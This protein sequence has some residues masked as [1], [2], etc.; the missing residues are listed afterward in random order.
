VVRPGDAAVTSM[1]AGSVPRPFWLDRPDVV[2]PDPSEPLRG[3]HDADL[4]IIGAGFT[5]LWAAHQ[6]L[7]DDADRDVI[8]LEAGSVGD[9]ASGRNGGFC[10]ASITHGHANGTA[11]FGDEFPTLNRLGNENLAGLLADLDRHGVDAS[12]EP[13][14]ELSVATAGWQVDHLYEDAELLAAHGEDVAVLDLEAVRAEVASPTFLAGVWRR[15]NV[16]LIDPARL[17]FG[18]R[19]ALGRRGGRV[20]EY[21]PVTALRRDG[22]GVLLEGPGLSLTARQVLLA[23]NAFPGLVPAVRR[24]VAPVYDHVLVTEPLPLPVRSALGWRNR[25]GLADSANQF[26]YFRLTPDDRLLWGGYDAIYHWRG[27]VGPAV[28]TRESTERLLAAQLL[29][30]F[31]QLEGIAVTHRWGGPIATTTRFTLT[32]GSRWGGRVSWAVGYTGLGVGASRFGARVALDLLAGQET[33]RTRLRLVRRAPVPFPP[34]PLRWFGINLT[35]RA[36]ARADR[37]A[38]RRGPWLG[39]LDRAGVGFDS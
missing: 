23:T 11:H 10:D 6:A 30:C 2:A 27:R 39:L 37:R 3:R 22:S 13:V 20:H 7:D 33:E 29:E 1:L 18:L 4:V 25:Q 21:T 5:G 36:I 9:G 31:P 34:E 35:R 12:W 19:A 38:G 14:G 8:V 15:S 24:A 28:E 32:A 26:H 16:G 17:V